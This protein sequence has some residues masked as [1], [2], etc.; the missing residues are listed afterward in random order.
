MVDRRGGTVVEQGA[1]GAARL[2]G[3]WSDLVVIVGAVRW[4]GS[5]MVDHHLA[6]GLARYGPVLYVDPP[7]P[8]RPGP[9]AAGGPHPGSRRTDLELI[10]PGLALVTPHV[11]PGHQRSGMKPVS[12]ALVRRTMRKAVAELGAP[13]V[14]AV[15]VP[16]LD[17]CLGALGET[18]RVFYATDD[19]VAGSEL[20]RLSARRL[21]REETRQLRDA[22][23]VVA[24]SPTL[25]DNFRS[26]GHDPVLLPNG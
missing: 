23:L 10:R 14:R 7:K 26:R 24:A 16:S 20:M 18:R 11:L 1:A 3:D 6:E 13:A 4:Q 2:P 21:R 17:R 19:F 15:I 12:I 22:D 9:D 8:W 5:R 25:A